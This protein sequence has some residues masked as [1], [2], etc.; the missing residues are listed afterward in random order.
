LLPDLTSVIKF[1]LVLLTMIASS[2]GVAVMIGGSLVLRK[3]TTPGKLLFSIGGGVGSVGLVINLI[4]GIGL[5]WALLSSVAAIFVV[6]QSLEW[7]RVILS[8]VARVIA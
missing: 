1:T 3:R 2:G 6:G 7:I 5:A 4:S 8:V